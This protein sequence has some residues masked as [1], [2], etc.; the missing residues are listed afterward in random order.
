MRAPLLLACAA[1][2]WLGGCAPSPSLPVPGTIALDV[3]FV[4]PKND[5]CAATSLSS[6]SRYWQIH[7]PFLPRLSENDLERL[8]LVPAKKGTLQDELA[9]ASRQNGFVVYP[10]PKSME[11]LLQELTNGHP[12]IVLLNRSLFLYPLWHYSVVTGFDPATQNVLLHFADTPHEAISLKTFEK[13]WERSGRWGIVPLPPSRVAATATPETALKAA[14]DVERTAYGHDAITAYNAALERWGDESGLLFALA[15][16]HGAR[17]EW[18]RAEALYRRLLSRDP[19][20]PY[21]LNNLAWIL[22]DK[23][24]KGAAR[25]MLEEHLKTEGKGGEL[26]RRSCEEMK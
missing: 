20:H 13:M 12:V 8:T 22:Y 4:T 5:L 18:N 16:A 3:P 21:A 2:L 10:L 25:A 14:W 7:A 17:G 6:V 24:E 1:A 15:A 9:A 19:H 23:G 11:A 26:I